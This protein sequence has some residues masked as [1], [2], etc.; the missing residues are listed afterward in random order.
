VAPETRVGASEASGHYLATV[1]MLA[2][3][4]RDHLEP[5]AFDLLYGPFAA[6][7]P[8]AELAP[9]Q[10]GPPRPRRGVARDA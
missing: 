7:I 1:A 3:L 6:R 10:G 8:P 4:A 9:E 2:L 5:A